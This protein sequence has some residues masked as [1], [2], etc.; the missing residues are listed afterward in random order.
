MIDSSK[1][2]LDKVSVTMHYHHTLIYLIKQK[3]L[4]KIFNNILKSSFKLGV[5]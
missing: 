4:N 2:R 3:I 1:F 5:V